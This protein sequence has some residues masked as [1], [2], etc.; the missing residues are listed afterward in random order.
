MEILSDYP[1]TKYIIK[2]IYV[3]IKSKIYIYIIIKYELKLSLFD[4]F[5]CRLI[6]LNF[7][8]TH[9]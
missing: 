3:L 2:C 6:S 4:K 9:Q 8:Q 7:I 5:Q 1:N